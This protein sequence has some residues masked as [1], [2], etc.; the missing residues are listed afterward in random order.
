MPKYLT[1]EDD[2]SRGARVLPAPEWVPLGRLESSVAVAAFTADNIFEPALYSTYS[3]TGILYP[4]SDIVSL[5]VVLRTSAPADLA[6]AFRA[7]GTW[8]RVDAAGN[9]AFGPSSAMA[10]NVRTIDP[11]YVS[12]GVV[13]NEFRLTPR[14][15]DGRPAFA[16]N[17]MWDGISQFWL[18]AGG[19][20][21]TVA[22]FAGIKFSFSTGNIRPESWLE[23]QGKRK[24]TA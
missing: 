20:F 4:V 16:Y 10:S 11:A 12:S 9:L 5:N 24:Q 22:S 2:G 15:I 13:I 3:I 8:Y 18:V 17:L 7:A 19:E 14:T 1:L 6:G 21:Q 23:I